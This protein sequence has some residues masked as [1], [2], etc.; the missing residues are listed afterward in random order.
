M[1]RVYLCMITPDFD[2]MQNEDMM[3]YLYFLWNIVNLLVLYLLQ[4]A[5]KKTLGCKCCVRIL[6]EYPFFMICSSLHS[7]IKLVFPITCVGHN[8]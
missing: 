4:I 2:G 3:L 7:R 8:R 6:I 1:I 5:L